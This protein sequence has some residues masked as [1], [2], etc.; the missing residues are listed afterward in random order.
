MSIEQLN[1][2]HAA[3]RAELTADAFNRMYRLA[4]SMFGRM[5]RDSLIS[6]GCRDEHSAQETFDNAIWELSERDDLLNFATTLSSALLRKRL[7]V[8]R[9]NGRRRKR[10][11]GSL[12]ETVANESGEYSPK[13]PTPEEPS[14]EEV[15]MPNLCRKKEDDQRQLIDFLKHSGKPDAT[16]T[17]IVEAFLFAPPS[18]SDTAIA[19][20]IGIHHETAKRKLRKLARQYDAN[21]FGDVSDYLAV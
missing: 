15:A 1:S 4:E 17:A 9:G 2:L 3:Y 10:I 19:E 11:P 5:H 6:R 18:A 20:S 7:M 8:F 21:R 13:Y 14:A 12:D 16:T